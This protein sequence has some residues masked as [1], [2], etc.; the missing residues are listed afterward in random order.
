[1]SLITSR[2]VLVPLSTM[3]VAGAI[4][5]GSGATFTSQSVSAAAV[6][7]GTLKH[8]NSQ[9]GATLT[10]ADLRPGATRTGSLTITNDGTIDSTLTLQETADSSTFVPGDLT[11]SITQAGVSTPLYQGN[12]GG[13][14]NG[15]RL[16]LGALPVGASTTVTFTVSMP[17]SA[18]NANQGKAASASYQYV[19]TQVAGSSTTAGWF[20]R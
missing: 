8:A 6:T 15:V 2:K 17:E 16:A 13:L 11:L 19:T 20:R 9:D 18:G 7:T 14:D 4:A 12:F 5:V 10:I 1:M 3:L